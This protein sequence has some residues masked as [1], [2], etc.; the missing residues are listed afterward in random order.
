MEVELL[1][2]SYAA[3]KLIWWQQF[4]KEVGFNPKEKQVI[5]YNNI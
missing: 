4:F 3:T 5:Y 1:A 2:L